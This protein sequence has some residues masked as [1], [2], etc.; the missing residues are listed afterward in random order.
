MKQEK[1]DYAKTHPVK[2]KLIHSALR[3]PHLDHIVT[4]VTVVEYIFFLLISY[5]FLLHKHATNLSACIKSFNHFHNM[6]L[7][8][9]SD[10]I[11]DLFQY[12]S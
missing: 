1:A 10:T 6:L 4:Y 9:K 5:D 11:Y 8:M 3:T 12:E 7:C 2:G